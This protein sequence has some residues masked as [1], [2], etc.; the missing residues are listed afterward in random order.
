MFDECEAFGPGV[1]PSDACRDRAAAAAAAAN[2]RD[3]LI[4]PSRRRRRRRR[5]PHRRRLLRLLR[6]RRPIPHR[7]SMRGRQTRPV[8]PGRGRRPAAESRSRATRLTRSPR[9]SPCCRRRP[10]PRAGSSSSR[11]A[12]CA[13]RRERCVRANDIRR[14]HGARCI[15]ADGADGEMGLLG[16]AFHPD[17]PTDPRVF[18]SYTAGTDSADVRSS[19]EFRLVAGQTARRS[20]RPPSRCC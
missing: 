18:L 14:H 4:H 7:D 19:R 13:V 11:P 3:R 12:S 15:A 8:S 17:F 16:M 9:Q 1:V 10:T 2:R 20:I 6:R 5:R